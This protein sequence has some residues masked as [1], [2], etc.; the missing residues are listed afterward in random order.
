MRESV[1]EHE[2]DEAAITIAISD[3]AVVFSIFCKNGRFIIRISASA[4]VRLP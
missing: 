1:P 3:N 4:A 2:A